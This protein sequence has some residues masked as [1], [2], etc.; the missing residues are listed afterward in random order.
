VRPN[1]VQLILSL[2]PEHR[3]SDALK[4]LKGRSSAALC[5]QLKLAPPLWA[6]GYLARSTGKVR[7]QAVKQYL[8]RQAEHHGYDKRVLPPVFRFRNR[9]PVVLHV[10]HAS[11]DLKHHLVLATEY[12]QG[13]FDSRLGEA[14]VSYWNRVAAVRGFA[15]D[16]RQ[17]SRIT[18]MHWCEY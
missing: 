13:I 17:C 18:C 14:L 2:R 5:S 7:V 11:F 6:V 16:R 15:L 10:A 9:N 8:E 1:D 12:R 4:K 3:I